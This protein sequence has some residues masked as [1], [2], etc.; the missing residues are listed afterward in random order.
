MAMISGVFTSLEVK[1][2]DGTV[3]YDRAVDEDFYANYM[4]GFYTDGVFP[5]PTNTFQVKA[6]TS[7]TVRILPGKALI[8]GRFCYNEDETSL[9]IHNSDNNLPRRDCIVLRLDFIN[10]EIVLDVKTGTAASSP[11]A[12]ALTRDSDT[13]EL[14]LA[15]V[16]VAA[17]STGVT[18][19]NITDTRSNTSLCGYV[20]P[21]TEVIDAED[22]MAQLNAQFMTWFNDCKNT[23]DANAAGN[24]LNKINANKTAA[25][26]AIEAV[27]DSLDAHVQAIESDAAHAPVIRVKMAGDI[28]RGWNNDG[29]TVYIPFVN[30]YRNGVKKA[31][32]GELQSDGSVLIRKAGEYFCGFSLHIS[33]NPGWDDATFHVRLL[34]NVSGDNIAE[35]YIRC[36]RTNSYHQVSGCP[37]NR[38]YLR[39][40]D[41]VKAVI[42]TDLTTGYRVNGQQTHLTVAPIRF[43]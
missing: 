20:S 41:V 26:E 21:L 7:K 2:A 18:Q 32:W 13:Y 27:Q 24:L 29:G 28:V 16:Y 36:S 19:G 22:F 4:K 15:T 33:D 1:E 40:G 31:D 6:A 30:T 9:T 5:Y 8:K 10:R 11:A 42:H 34:E 35:E 17:G 38:F 25:D 37:S 3:T 39:K 12:P 43:D 14:C 23:I